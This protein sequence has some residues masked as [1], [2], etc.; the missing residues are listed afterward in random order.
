VRRRLAK[1]RLVE[2][3]YDL[4]AEAYLGNEEADD[5][6]TDPPFEQLMEMLPAGAS[7]LDLGCGSGVPFT[8]RL[9][10]RC[11]VTGVDISARQL[12]LARAHVPTAHFIKA[13]MT[14]VE[15]PAGSFD[16]VVACF[17]IIH[18]PREEQ[19]PLVARV[20]SWLRPGGLFLATWAVE[21]WEGAGEWEGAMVWWSHY[22]P[23]TSLGLLRAA[24]LEIVFTERGTDGDETWL[25]VL[26]RKQ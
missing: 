17:S 7:A 22:D 16:A 26:A 6:E 8:R 13:D 4:V 19:G 21:A 1:H 24:G 11:E 25:W 12:A 15:F 14:T 3:G 18:V 23:D 10:A 5:P 20:H 9:A 2:R